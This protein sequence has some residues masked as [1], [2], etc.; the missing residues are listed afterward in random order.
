MGKLY[1]DMTVEEKEKH[2]SNVEKYRKANPEIYRK[3]A[4]EQYYKDTDAASVRAKEW[5]SNNLEYI[6]QKQRENK[7]VR[8]NLAIAYLGGMCN[9]C[10]NTFH[11][12][13]Y[14]FHHVDPATKDRDPSKMLSLK[15]ERVTTELDKCILLCANC[16][17]LTHHESNY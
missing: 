1:R 14:E 4:K 9:K 11:P 6:K 7:R 10:K 16:H 3:A 17:R 8:K 13:V 2:K 5:R 12:A 15:W